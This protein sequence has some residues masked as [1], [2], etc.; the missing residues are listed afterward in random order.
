MFIAAVVVF[1][2]VVVVVVV[3]L[4]KRT[5]NQTTQIARQI[6]FGQRINSSWSFSKVPLSRARACHNDGRIKYHDTSSNNVDRR[7]VYNNDTTVQIATV[8]GNVIGLF[9]VFY[10][11]LVL[12]G[13]FCCLL[14][15][16]IFVWCP[17]Q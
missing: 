12:V 10:F 11:F 3:S 8:T 16:F 17:R 1:V 6:T 13:C 2:V 14:L 15:I 9:S 7:I 4:P 5:V